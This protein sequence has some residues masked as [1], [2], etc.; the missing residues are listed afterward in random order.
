MTLPVLVIGATGKTGRRLVPELVARQ[1]AVRAASRGGSA[2]AGVE[3]TRFEWHDAGTYRPALAGIGAVYLVL[4]PFV[5]DPTPLV[6][7]LLRV[8]GAA[9]VG[10]IVLLTAI[11]VDR[12][13]ATAPMRR[14]ELL[15]EDSGIPSTILRP[16]AFMENFSE[17]HWDGARA[18]IAERD[19][20]VLPGGP[21][22][23]GY[24]SADDIAAV[25]AAALTEDGHAGKGYALTGPEALTMAEIAALIGAGV[26]RP[27]RHLETDL[28][29]I[30]AALH[31]AG[32]PE[33]YLA[34]MTD[35][36]QTALLSGGM[37]TLSDDVALVTGR[38]PTSFAAFAL[39]AAERGAWQR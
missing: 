15:V 9:G 29:G 34:Y 13:D 22:R 19:E 20:F 4:P 7:P 6:E 37:S 14:V 38:P 12:A 25:A 30:R 35:L 39:A 26:G 18:S 10:R 31:A 21:T 23:V 24:V 8:A 28:D 1:V 5:V 27:I 36:Y 17:P 2:P 32:A 16:A 33:D 11:G 3:P